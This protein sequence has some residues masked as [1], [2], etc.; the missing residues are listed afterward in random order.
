MKTVLICLLIIFV[1]AICI[2]LYAC[3]VAAGRADEE[4]E[5]QYYDNMNKKGG[6]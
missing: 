2:L 3:L 5:K 6:V 1:L 4:M